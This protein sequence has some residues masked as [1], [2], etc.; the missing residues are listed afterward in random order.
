[1]YSLSSVYTNKQIDTLCN[2]L[3]KDG[4]KLNKMPTCLQVYSDGVKVLSAV[5]PVKNKWAVQVSQSIADKYS[6]TLWKNT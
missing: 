5:N 2:Q 4:F 3:V 1:M 6:L